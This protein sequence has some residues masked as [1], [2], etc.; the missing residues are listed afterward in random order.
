MLV[1]TLKEAE[2]GE[3]GG[4][5][6]WRYL[7]NTAAMRRFFFFLFPVVLPAF[8]FGLFSLSE[9]VVFPSSKT[10]SLGFKDKFGVTLPTCDQSQCL[11]L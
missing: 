1:F 6:A 8:Q 3:G 5:I 4:G 10:K 2:D 7:A 9:L 11:N